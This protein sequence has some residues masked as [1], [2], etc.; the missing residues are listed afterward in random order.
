MPSISLRR[1]NDAESYRWT[2]S[3]PEV[4]MTAVNIG[5]LLAAYA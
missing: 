1:M 5:L 2:L 4:Q 3:W